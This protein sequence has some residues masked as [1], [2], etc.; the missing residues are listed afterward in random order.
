MKPYHA[1]LDAGVALGKVYQAC[2][3]NA[4][5][6]EFEV[7]LSND[8]SKYIHSMDY[9]ARFH[10]VAGEAP[11]FAELGLSPRIVLCHLLLAR[12]QGNNG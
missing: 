9:V 3:T 1:A 5:C 12:F 8:L 7:S 2:G 4:T 6:P 10:D 11:D